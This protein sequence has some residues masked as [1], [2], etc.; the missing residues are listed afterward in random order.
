MR[1]VMAAMDL[2]E[3]ERDII[4]AILSGVPRAKLAETMFKTASTI[5]SQIGSI[6][7]K[8]QVTTISEVMVKI[9]NSGV[10]L[11]AHD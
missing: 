1:Q 6:L 10:F 3:Q 11:S 5:K 9:R 7:K 2:T 8:L 4:E